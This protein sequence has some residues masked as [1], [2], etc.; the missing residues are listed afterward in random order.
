M[1]ACCTIFM[2]LSD[3]LTEVQAATIALLAWPR[4]MQQCKAGSY[5]PQLHKLYNRML[6]RGRNSII[7][8]YECSTQ[9][10]RQRYVYMHI[11]HSV[12]CLTCVLSVAAYFTNA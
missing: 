4:S 12:R 7:H 6:L 5:A 9:H 1:F 8:V 2:C 11:S 10:E 3:M